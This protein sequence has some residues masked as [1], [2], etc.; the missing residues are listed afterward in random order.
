MAEK[1]TYA[2][3]YEDYNWIIAMGIHID[4]VEEYIDQTNQKSK[5]LAHSLLLRL[6][7]ML[8][9]VVAFCLALLILVEKL[10]FRQ[11]KK[12]MELEINKDSLTKASSRRCG[13]NDLTTA[14]KNYQSNGVSP[15]VMMFDVTLLRASMTHMDMK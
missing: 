12:Q 5:E 7:L 9:M 2:K 13:T 15:A 14:F 8:I 10:H 4:D 6:V 3:L 1:L 11:T